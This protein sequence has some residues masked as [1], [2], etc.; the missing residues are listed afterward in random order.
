[1]VHR[2]ENLMSCFIIKIHW[3]LWVLCGLKVNLGAEKSISPQ[4]FFC[5][6]TERPAMLAPW[7]PALKARSST[8][9]RCEIIGLVR[10]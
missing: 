2:D 9:E 10:S 3:L 4:R 6:C 1:M 7:S 5:G 8:G